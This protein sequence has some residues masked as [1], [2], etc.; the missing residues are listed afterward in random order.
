MATTIAAPASPAPVAAAAPAPVASPAP[1]SGPT[2]AAPV[3]APVSPSSSG[4][5]SK[6]EA[7]QF[8]S[9][10][11]YA[12]AVL[13]EQL[14]AI[15]EV[16]EEAPAEVADPIA[17]VEVPGAE[18][19]EV[20][21]VPAPDAEPPV[22]EE[23][24]E[25]PDFDFD[26]PAIVTPEALSK[27]VTDNPEF[28]KLLEADSR[29]KGQLFKTAREAAELQPYREIFPD[30]EMAKSAATAASQFDSV[31]NVFMGSTTREGAQ[32]AL[33]NIAELA[34]ERDDNGDVVM[35]NG[36]PVIGEDF[37]G[38]VDNT[39]R[40]DI[41]NRV[42][43]V[44]QR[45][46]ANKYHE[47]SQF[48]TQEQVNA[49]Y[50]KD[51]QSIVD[52]VGEIMNPD[53]SAPQEELPSHLQEKAKALELREQKLNEREQ[54]G[55]VQ[56]RQQFEQGIVEESHN[57]IGA[58][59]K[60]AIST[61]KKNGASI[62]P[63]VEES[64]GNAIGSRLIAKL[65]SIPGIQMEMQKLQA[66]PAN[67]ASK[68]RRLAAIDRQIQQFAP[69]IIKDVFKEAGIQTTATAKERAAKR[70]AQAEAT[71]QTE[72]KGSRGASKSTGPLSVDDAFAQAETEWTKAHPGR[73]YDAV[74]RNQMMQRIV[75]LQLP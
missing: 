39:V 49:A 38:F 5:T 9:R 34:Y 21:E 53:A 18:H 26:P 33:Q 60:G 41:E 62:Q 27:M 65:K 75:Q 20:P 13:A 16:S 43:D 7:S 61:V 35:Q 69:D 71:K 17:E 6:V 25:E 50:A 4:P 19:T 44:W 28:G 73:R 42:G 30:V 22:V 45:F 57:R 68:T 36:S 74:A 54:G 58:M 52:A 47:D 72:I 59:V 55:K 10:N 2:Q 48:T 24:A 3:S 8:K 40:M 63:F 11:A 64:M 12:E 56:S 23:A 51:R 29:L 31:R 70:D 15:P 1:V 14:A 67:A 46:S 37:Y 66:L 32:K